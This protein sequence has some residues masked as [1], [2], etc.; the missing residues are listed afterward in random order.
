MTADI[1]EP[2]SSVPATKHH[3]A[4]SHTLKTSANYS[5]VSMCAILP[6][7]EGFLPILG[8]HLQS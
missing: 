3:I 5:F 1:R 8:Y 4:P 2:F 6:V 7:L